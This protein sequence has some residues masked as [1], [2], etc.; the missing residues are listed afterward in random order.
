MKNTFCSFAICIGPVIKCCK[1]LVLDFFRKMFLQNDTTVARN[2]QFRKFGPLGGE[3]GKKHYSS[4]STRKIP[5]FH[6]EP[7]IFW[8]N[9][10]RTSDVMKRVRST[11]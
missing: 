10:F 2:I 3:L 6:S 8:N 1:M 7:K 5:N 11:S 9:Y 4:I